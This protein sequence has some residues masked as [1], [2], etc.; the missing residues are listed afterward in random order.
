MR[1]IIIGGLLALALA[2]SAVGLHAQGAVTTEA[3]PPVQ[4]GQPQR[5]DPMAQRLATC[6]DVLSGV[7][8]GQL[9]DRVATAQMF[10]AAFEAANP[11]KTLGADFKVVEKDPK[12]P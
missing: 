8:S 3:K 11:G 6:V 7:V 10:K 5:L 2:T 9:V 4:Y 1:R 12:R